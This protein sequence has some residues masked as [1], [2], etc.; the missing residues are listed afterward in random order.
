MHIPHNLELISQTVK[1]ACA[2]RLIACYWMFTDFE[3]E[4]HCETRVFCSV[5]TAKYSVNV[6]QA[7]M[8]V[9]RISQTEST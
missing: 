3:S 2:Q 4:M 5:Y 8:R 9:V 1:K 7:D 6:D